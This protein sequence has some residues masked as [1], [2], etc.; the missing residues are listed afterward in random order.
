MLIHGSA[1]GMPPF[2]EWLSNRPGT[3]KG[4]HWSLDIFGAEMGL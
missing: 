2:R 3:L 1:A 4:C